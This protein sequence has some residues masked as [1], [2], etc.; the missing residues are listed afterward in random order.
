MKALNGIQPEI[1]PNHASMV[2][3]PRSKPPQ[4]AGG[5]S[6]PRGA[7]DSRSPTASAAAGFQPPRPAQTA[8]AG[9]GYGSPQESWSGEWVLREYTFRGLSYLVDD[10]TRCDMNA[11]RSVHH[12]GMF[13]RDGCCIIAD[14]MPGC[15]PGR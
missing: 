7:Y 11:T 10:R 2:G 13:G 9:G 12:T 4:P 15:S 3:S 6:S 5:P 14:C 1:L 8:G